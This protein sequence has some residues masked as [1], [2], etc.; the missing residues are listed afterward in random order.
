MFDLLLRALVPI[1][2]L[3]WLSMSPLE[4]AAVLASAWSVWCYARESV[5]AWPAGLLGV[6]FYLVICF[7]VRLYADA[8]L[9]AVYIAL[10]VYGWWAWL[11]GGQNRAALTISR[12]SPRL[13][14][15]L[16]AIGIAAYLPMGWLLDRYTDTDVPWWD[17]LPT[18]SSL[19]AQWM[20][21]RKKLENWWVWIAT[22]LVYIPLF[23]YKGLYLT[24]ILY[25]VFIILCLK[26]LRTWR[27]SLRV[28]AA[29]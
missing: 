8:G 2:A 3:P 1:A 20:I 19:I 13:W 6:A 4:I 9:Q 16:A 7:D 27:A 28:S 22:D 21:T 23:A 25:G 5:W 29:A 14:L 10:Q 17:S 24:A 11:H 26:G 18:V 12:C 15:V